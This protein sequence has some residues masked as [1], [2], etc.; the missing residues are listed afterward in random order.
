MTKPEAVAF[1]DSV[2]PV[3]MDVA[4]VDKAKWLEFK[5]YIMGVLNAPAPVADPKW[6]EAVRAINAIDDA[7]LKG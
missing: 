2:V 3:T 1:L 4:T 7:L 5:T 6:E